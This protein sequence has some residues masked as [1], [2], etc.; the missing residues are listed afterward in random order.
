MITTRRAIVLAAMMLAASARASSADDKTS[1]AVSDA[2]SL[3]VAHRSL[4]GRQVVVRHSGMEQAVTV[5]WDF[6]SGSLR[7]RIARNI[8]VLATVERTI[9][10]TRQ[11]IIRE[12]LTGMP[13]DKDGKRPSSIYPGTPEHEVFTRQF[14][15]ALRER[16]SLDLSRI[17]ASDLRLDKNEIPVTTLTALAPILDD[18]LPK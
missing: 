16:V 6:A 3:L 13:A 9:E 17:K 14:T 5:P 10:E 1:M 2:L 18:D 12:I 11:T 7:L 4:D 15:A 8:A